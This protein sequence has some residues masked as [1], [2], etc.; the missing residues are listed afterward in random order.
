M[1]LAVRRPEVST[2]FATFPC[3][4]QL[5]FKDIP[6]HVLVLNFPLLLRK[7]EEKS[8]F[9]TANTSVVSTESPTIPLT[10]QTTFT[11]GLSGDTANPQACP[12]SDAS[13]KWGPQ[14]TGA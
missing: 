11:E 7:L 10:P 1:H 14:A 8:G 5:D 4:F 12:T 6:Y 9:P 13:D 3:C 2:G